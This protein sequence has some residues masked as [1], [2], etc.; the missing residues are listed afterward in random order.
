VKLTKR[1]FDKANDYPATGLRL[2]GPNSAEKAQCFEICPSISQA[3]TRASL[4]LC[5]RI[6]NG[7]NG[8]APPSCVSKEAGPQT[9][10]RYSKTGQKRRFSLVAPRRTTRGFDDRA[11]LP[12]YSPGETPINPLKSLENRV[13]KCRIT[14]VLYKANETGSA[15]THRA[16]ALSCDSGSDKRSTI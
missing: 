14:P 4:T 11:Q 9:N 5:T 2:D 12:C 3:K 10:P 8:W 7:F 16:G 15:D 6:A 1:V 13:V